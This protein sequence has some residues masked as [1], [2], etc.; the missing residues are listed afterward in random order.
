M[1]LTSTQEYPEIEDVEDPDYDPYNKLITSLDIRQQLINKYTNVWLRDYLLSLK[2]NIALGNE[3]KTAPELQVGQV[4]LM[5]V[6]TSTRPFLKLVRIVEHIPS[7]DGNLR[8]VK[9]KMAE[10]SIKTIA[11]ANLIPLE[12]GDVNIQE[13]SLKEAE[14][15]SEKV[16]P[17][18]IRKAEQDNVV[19][20]FECSTN[21]NR[22]TPAR[23]AAIRS[24]SATKEILLHEGEW[25]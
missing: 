13:P 24:R 16:D 21:S 11:I 5:Q 20:Q 2:R 23:D 1:I 4:A 12:I 9:V 3:N 22:R 25:D 7:N 19:S 15:S 8:A 17:L 10:G 14:L 6:P 18:C